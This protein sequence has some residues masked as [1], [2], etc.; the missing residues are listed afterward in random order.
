[1]NGIGEEV[2]QVSDENDETA[3]GLGEA[4]YVSELE[5][6][7]CADANHDADEKASKEDAKEDSHSFKQAQDTKCLCS[8]FVLLGGFEQDDGDG[9][10]QDGFSENEGVQLRFDLVRV[11]DGEDGDGVGG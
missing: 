2:G 3:L 4:P 6:Q 1:M 5:R 9:I 8:I 7:R 10:I 11:E